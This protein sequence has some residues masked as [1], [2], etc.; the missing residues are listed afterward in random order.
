MEYKPH[1][2]SLREFEH[3][4]NCQSRTSADMYESNQVGVKRGIFSSFCSASTFSH[5]GSCGTAQYGAIDEHI[6]TLK[7]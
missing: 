5:A 7:T 4:C 3:L 6:F 1:D 2:V